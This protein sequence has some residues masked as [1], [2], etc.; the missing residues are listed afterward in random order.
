MKQAWCIHTN[1]QSLLAL[2]YCGKYGAHSRIDAAYYEFKERNASWGWLGL[3]KAASKFKEVLSWQ[4][5]NGCTI[6]ILEDKWC[7]NT[8]IQLLHLI[9][10]THWEQ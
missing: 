3:V 10:P 1:P 4:I 2:L 9:N 5:R 6:R 7:S 8:K